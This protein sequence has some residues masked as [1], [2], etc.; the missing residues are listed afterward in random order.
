MFQHASAAP[1]DRSFAEFVAMSQD[2][3]EGAMMTDMVF[4]AAGAKL[5][6]LGYGVYQFSLVKAFDITAL[7]DREAAFPVD[8][9]IHGIHVTG[10]VVAC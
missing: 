8:K 9:S 6:A 2:F 10:S 1:Y 7:S 5:F 3:A 4:S